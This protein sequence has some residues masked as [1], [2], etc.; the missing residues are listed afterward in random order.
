MY[1]VKSLDEVPAT[2]KDTQVCT[3]DV[4]LAIEVLDEVISLAHLPG[5]LPPLVAIHLQMHGR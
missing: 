1:L 5:T 3:H 2:H 4:R